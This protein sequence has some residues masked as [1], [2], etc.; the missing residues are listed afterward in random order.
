M[1]YN[2][3]RVA[4]LSACGVILAGGLI[5]SSLVLSRFMV[6][7]QK[8]NSIAVKG[9]A[10]R[11]VEADLGAFDCLVEI[12]APDV[13]GGYL[14]I[15]MAYNKVLKRIRAAGFGE[16]EIEEGPLSYRACNKIVAGKESNEFSH[17][18]F[19][20]GLTVRSNRVDMIAEQSQKLNELLAEGVKVNVSAPSFFISDP[21]QYKLDLITAATESAAKRAEAIAAQC[22][23]KVG[24]LITARQGI[25]Q[26]TRPASNDTSDYGI[27]DT[28]SRRKVVKIVVSLDFEI[29]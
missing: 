21:E 7:I 16:G 24:K 5:G 9:V 25:I 28:S 4:A 26:I 12:N 15:N 18:A 23:G 6:K 2:V 29:Q 13:Q 22:R 1:E 17:Y 14:A 27:Y 10:E 8:E 11:E 3:N 19:S 20:R